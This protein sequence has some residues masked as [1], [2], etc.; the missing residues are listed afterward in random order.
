MLGADVR[1]VHNG[2]AA[3]EAVATYKP[4]A[5]LLDIGT[6][7]RSRV[8]SPPSHIRARTASTTAA[9]FGKTEKIPKRRSFPATCSSPTQTVNSPRSPSTR[10]AST[11]S[12]L[13]SVAARPAALGRYAQ[14]L[15]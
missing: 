13:F 7:M 3:L 11:P 9:S 12:S 10:F 8:S 15:Q 6:S 14:L 4:A 5:V 1:V 2:A